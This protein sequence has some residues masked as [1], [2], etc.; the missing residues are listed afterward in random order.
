MTQEDVLE[1]SKVLDKRMPSPS[2]YW[3]LPLMCDCRAALTLQ[4][5]KMYE[6][7]NTTIDT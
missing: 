5:S 1:R 3:C 4:G 2:L 7:E 6:K